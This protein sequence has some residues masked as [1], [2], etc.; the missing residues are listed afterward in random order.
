M[1]SSQRRAA[2]FVRPAQAPKRPKH[3]TFKASVL[4]VS[5]N[6]DKHLAAALDSALAQQVDFPIEIVVADDASTDGTKDLIAEYQRHWPGVVKALSPQARLGVTRNYQRGFRACAGEYIAVLEG[7]DYWVGEERLSTMVAFLEHHRECAIAFNRILLQDDDPPCC[8]LLQ[9]DSAQPYELK[10]GAELAYRN[11]IGN[12]SACVY[13]SVI[14]HRMDP[15]IY[16]FQMYDWFFNLAMSRYGL[17]GYLPRV[18]SVYRQHGAGTWSGMGPEQRLRETI[19]VIP[20]YDKLLDGVYTQQL[21]AHRMDARAEIESLKLR[22]LRERFPWNP[23]V[24]GYVLL[25]RVLRKTRLRALA[26]VRRI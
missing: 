22:Q 2:S 5:Y 4:V 20:T 9:W 18:M 19:E 25:R 13:R 16:H 6:H 23:A 15:R 14:V 26:A 7:D 11:F 1:K 12:F 21:R 8:S 17:I 10:T 3:S 24:A